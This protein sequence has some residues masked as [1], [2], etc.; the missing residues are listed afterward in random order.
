[1]KSSLYKMEPEPQAPS[2]IIIIIIAII[3]FMAII[4]IG[5]GCHTEANVFYNQALA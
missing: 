1:M 5:G 2:M 4:I 3:I